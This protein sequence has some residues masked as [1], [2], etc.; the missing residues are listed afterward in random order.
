MWTITHPSSRDHSRVRLKSQRVSQAH[1]CGPLKPQTPTRDPME[2]WSTASPQETWKVCVCVCDR[3]LIQIQSENDYCWYLLCFLYCFSKFVVPL[4][5]PIFLSVSLFP[6]WVCNFICWGRVK[7]EERCGAGQ[8]NY[9]L[10]Q[11]HHYC[12]RSGNAS[13]QRYGKHPHTHSVHTYT[14]HKIMNRW[15]CTC[16]WVCGKKKC[17]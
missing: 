17:H 4:Y 10:L 2:K 6:R 5:L 9:R 15:E 14:M 16:S 11:H 8:R 7:S 12:Q 3:Q 1:V 13:A